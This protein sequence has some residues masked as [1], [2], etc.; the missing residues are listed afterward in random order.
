MVW[1][2]F[3]ANNCPPSYVLHYIFGGQREVDYCFLATWDIY[4]STTFVKQGQVA[5]DNEVQD[6][7]SSGVVFLTAPDRIVSIEVTTNDNL[8]IIILSEFY[9]VSQL[10]CDW[11]VDVARQ[12]YGAH[13]Y[14]Y[15]MT[16]LVLDFEFKGRHVSACEVAKNL[17]LT[18]LVYDFIYPDCSSYIVIVA[19]FA[20][21]AVDRASVHVFYFAFVRPGLLHKQ[22]IDF[23]FGLSHSNIVGSGDAHANI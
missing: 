15:H 22:N 7:V 4:R 16:L 23:S 19:K 1:E 17:P 21:V 14:I 2:T 5:F 8:Q 10:R 20:G 6:S 9:E 3:F 18:L 12:I 11:I 13:N